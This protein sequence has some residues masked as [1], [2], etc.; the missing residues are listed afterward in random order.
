MRTPQDNKPRT[1]IEDRRFMEIMENG[2]TKDE[3]GSWEA[4]L[5]FRHE[6]R[7][8][9]SSRYY[10][11]K[12]LKSTCRTLDKKPS[13]KV[14]YFSFMQKIFDLD[15][16]EVVPAENV[17]SDKPCWY[18]PHFGIYHPKKP[19]KIRV[20]F[21]SAAECNGISLN[22]LLLPGP[23]LT[24]SLLGVLIRFRQDPVAIVAN[25]EQM[26]HSFKVKKEHR[27]FLRFLWYKNNDPNRRNH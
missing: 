24:N 2:M 25:I 27:D 16:A 19:D 9:P 4:L 10:A 13:M 6:V 17:K 3:N 20:V 8:L 1:S 26:F 14:Q 22:K 21:D 23:D 7:E 5:P 15:H 18:L 11:M 12:R